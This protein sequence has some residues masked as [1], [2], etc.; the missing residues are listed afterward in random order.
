M[1]HYMIVTRW[2][3]CE[4]VVFSFWGEDKEHALEQ[5]DDADPHIG[6]NHIILMYVSDTEISNCERVV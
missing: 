1:K 4:V 2:G 5:F 6:R 3:D